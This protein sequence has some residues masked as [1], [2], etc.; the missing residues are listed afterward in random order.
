MILTE[1]MEK[2]PGLLDFTGAQ[3]ADAAAEAGGPDGPDGSG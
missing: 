2:A 1:V 3:S